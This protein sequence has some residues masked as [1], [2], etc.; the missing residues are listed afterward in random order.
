MFQKSLSAQVTKMKPGG[1]SPVIAF[2]TLR[3]GPFWDSISPGEHLFATTNILSES[4]PSIAFT[5]QLKCRLNS[6]R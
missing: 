2:F 5:A 6:A 4:E 1:S 3:K